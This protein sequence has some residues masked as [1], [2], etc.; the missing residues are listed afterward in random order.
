MSKMFR[1]LAVIIVLEL[2]AAFA[3]GRWLRSVSEGPAYY[4]GSAASQPLDVGDVRAP[5]LEPGQHEQ[6]VG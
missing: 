4:L 1:I 3:F 5:V 6:Q 2:I